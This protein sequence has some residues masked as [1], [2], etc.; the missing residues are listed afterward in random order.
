MAFS[1]FNM[2]KNI[3]TTQGSAPKKLLMFAAPIL[4]SNFV[5]QLYTIIDMIILGRY[6]A[7]GAVAAVGATASMIN[8]LLALVTGI[9]SGAS[10][11]VSQA[12]G[13]D[14]RKRVYKSVHTTMA[15]GLISSLLLTVFGLIFARN[16]L[17]LVNVP[18]TVITDATMYIRIIFIGFIPQGIFLMGTAILRAAGDSTRPMI[19]LG[20]SAIVIL[21]LDVLLVKVLQMN[22]IGAGIAQVSAHIVSAGLVLYTLTKSNSSYRLNIKEIKI[23]KEASKEIMRIGL[24]ATFQNIF[25]SGANTVVNAQLNKY[26]AFAV[27]GYA[28]SSKLD[29]LYYMTINGIA[30]SVQTFVGQNIGA[31]KKDRAKSGVK[32][33]LAMAFVGSA[34][35]VIVLTLLRRPLL[36]AFNMAEESR[37][38]AEFTMTIDAITYWTFAFGDILSA[39][40]RGAGHAIHPM[41][42]SFISMGV[43]RIGFSIG[44]QAIWPDFRAVLLTYPVTWI[45]KAILALAYYFKGTWLEDVKP[46]KSRRRFKAPRREVYIDQDVI[47]EEE[48]FDLLQDVKDS[49]KPGYL[50]SYIVHDPLPTDSGLDAAAETAIELA[51]YEDPNVFVSPEVDMSIFVDMDEMAEKEASNR[52]EAEDEPSNNSGVED[53]TSNHFEAED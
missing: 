44:I 4:F 25:I 2:M 21:V 3:D 43:L 38:Y 45:I 34:I 33:G 11:V 42:S 48:Y 50:P 26:G 18:D 14:D 53:V 1:P 47:D 51:I 5:Q 17:E 23:D 12:I 10:V 46:R 41:M 6:G 52:S 37:P 22:I 9:S 28:T 16:L 30:L 40:F 19:F 36:D 8:L 13:A 35:V 49:R 27:E 29:N 31:K 15:L 24:P 7:D 39:A 20:I 32:Y